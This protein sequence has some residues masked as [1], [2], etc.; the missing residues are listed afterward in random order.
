M[1]QV[2]EGT[3]ESL[4]VELSPGVLQALRELRF[5]H[6][7]P[8]QVGSGAALALSAPPSAR[9]QLPSFPTP[10]A[11]GTGCQPAWRRRRG[12]TALQKAEGLLP[13]WVKGKAPPPKLFHASCNTSNK[14]LT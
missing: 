1:E 3:W 12:K 2:T 6:M 4:P 8:V 5:S 10:R 7:T 14:T 13:I 9:F 11:D